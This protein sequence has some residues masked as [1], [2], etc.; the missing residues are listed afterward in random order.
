MLPLTVLSF[1]KYIREGLGISTTIRLQHQ[2]VF[3]LRPFYGVKLREGSS[4][5]CKF[6]C[7]ARNF[8]PPCARR[9]ASPGSGWCPRK[10]PNRPRRWPSTP[11]LNPA[12]R[13]KTPTRPAYRL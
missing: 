3:F 7:N 4:V 1:R 9:C 8:R 2:K 13:C 11:E 5:C 12:R 10:R 6:G